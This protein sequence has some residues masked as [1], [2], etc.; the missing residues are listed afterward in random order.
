MD[1]SSR[2]RE[3]NMEEINTQE[4][5]VTLLADEELDA[6]AGGREASVPSVSEIVV[7]KRLDKASTKLWN[8]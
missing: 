4:R 5:E 7:A 2:K 6:V 1:P 3:T 8:E